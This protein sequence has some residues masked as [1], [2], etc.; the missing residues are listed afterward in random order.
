MESIL[1]W[2]LA[3]IQVSWKY[4]QYFFYYP[5]DK[6]TNKQMDTCKNITSLKM[7]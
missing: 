7:K 2:D 5:A 3:S 1:A 6:P 4:V